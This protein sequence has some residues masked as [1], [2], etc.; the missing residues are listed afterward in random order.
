MMIDGHGH[1]GT[2]IKLYSL[3][4][5][6]IEETIKAMDRCGIAQIVMSHINAIS[7]D[8]RE[9]NNQL[10]EAVDQFPDRVVPFFALHPRYW[11]E[12]ADEIKRCAGD[13]GWRGLKLHPDFHSYPA[14]CHSALEAIAIAEAHGCIVMI[15]S[16][17][18]VTSR[19]ATPWMIG[20]VA[21]QFPRTRIIMAHMGMMDWQEAIE[22]AELYPNLIL[23]TTGSVNGY[24][25]IESA[26]ERLG[27][28][29]IIWGSDF[30]LMPFE[31][32]MSKIVDCD[33]EQG[34]KERIL[35]ENI[36]QI[37]GLRC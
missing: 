13:W 18:R 36:R 37:M 34:V 14:N 26:V 29:R 17:D 16:S 31:I 3:H 11:G 33:V 12:V 22:C 2:M 28:E 5:R 15:H 27:P 32:G 30:P 25:M 23:D 9:G 20:E 4:V 6:G 8:F 1:L 24:G 35:G 7:Y 10:K 19:Y 21:R